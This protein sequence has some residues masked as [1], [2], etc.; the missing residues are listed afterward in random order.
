M[1][2]NKIE[3]I[4]SVDKELKS[5]YFVND[6]MTIKELKE[7][8]LRRLQ[9]YSINYLIQYQ[10]RDYSKFET[11]KLTELFLNSKGRYEINLQMMDTFV[12]EQQE[13]QRVMISYEEAG[14]EFI[15][16]K[17]K[18]MRFEQIIPEIS[19]RVKFPEGKFPYN[20]RYCQIMKD[21]QLMISGG[22]N[23]D[24]SCC[25]YDYDTNYLMDLPSMNFERQNHTMINVDNDRVFVV[26]G[27]LSKK[28]ECFSLEY[29]DWKKYPDLNY[30]RKDPSCAVIKSLNGFFL[31]CFMGHSNSFSEICQNFERIKIDHNEIPE[32]WELFPVHNPFDL[33]F[34]RTH[35]AIL[36]I[37]ET[38]LL[39]IGGFFN[40]QSTKDI[41]FFD[42]EDYC[43]K[44]SQHKLP[45]STAFSEK[46][47]MTFDQGKEYY[48]FTYGFNKIIRWD[49]KK[50]IIGEIIKTKEKEIYN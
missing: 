15:I 20:S 14:T 38:G 41:A 46:W 34:V 6:S 23:Y 7:L 25:L 47:M 33:N 11:F 22:I 19:P 4:I 30:D 5:N 43:M 3:L 13:I 9:L 29:E 44:R 12:K 42:F 32:K 36:P 21:N 24:F 39:F 1:E 18:N 27:Y 48:L 35:F 26:G 49:G 31:Y 10:D 50:Q 16:Y 17:I 45:I 28:V 8:I 37:G 40:K 2:N